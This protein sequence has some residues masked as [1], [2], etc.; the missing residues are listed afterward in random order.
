MEKRFIPDIPDAQ[1]LLDLQLCGLKWTVNHAWNGSSFYRQHLLSAGVT[2][3]DIQSLEDLS[4]LPFTTSVHLKADILCRCFQYRKKKWYGFMP[5]QVP[6]ASAKSWLIP[7]RILM[8][9]ST[10]LPGVM[11]WRD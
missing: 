9:G 10:C 3:D 6:Q 7:R 5:L 8:T 2:P 4:R 11:K 1:A